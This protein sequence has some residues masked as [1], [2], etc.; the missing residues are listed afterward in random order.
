MDDLPSKRRALI[1]CERNN[2]EVDFTKPLGEGTDGIVFR[3]NRNSAVKILHA[4]KNYTTE[5]DCY[6]RLNAK[7]ITLIR[8]FNIPALLAYDDELLAIEMTIVKPPFV[9]DFGKV[10]LDRKPDFSEEVWAERHEYWESLFDEH[11]PEV[12]ILLAALEGLGIYYLDPK[13][14]NIMCEDWSSLE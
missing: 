1:Y 2:I 5:A 14:G 12:R 13:P 3:S 11:W 6:Q 8:Q 10:T 4:R 9:L 7:A